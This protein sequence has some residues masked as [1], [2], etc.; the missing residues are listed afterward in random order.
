LAS[1][2]EKQLQGVKQQ[3]IHG[4]YQEA[5]DVIGNVLNKKEISKEDQLAFKVLKCDILNDLGNHN[6]ALELAKEVLK[7]SEKLDKII[8][9][10]DASYQKAFALL[11]L[12]GKKDEALISIDRGLELIEKTGFDISDKVHILGNGWLLFLKGLITIG[13]GD[14]EKGIEYLNKSLLLAEECGNKRLI[15]RCLMMLGFAYTEKYEFK[16]AEEYCDKAQTIALELDNKFLLALTYFVKAP[17]RN[18]KRQFNE[19]IEFGE[20]AK[21]MLNEIGSKF[22]LFAL[23]GNLA[24][25]YKAISDFDTALEYYQKA[26]DYSLLQQNVT[27]FNMANLFYLKYDLKQSQKY[28]QKALKMSEEI[29]DLRIVPGALYH[30]VVLSIELDEMQEAKQYLKQLKQL[31]KETGYETINLLYCIAEIHV[32]KASNEFSDWGKAV[33]KLNKLLADN[34]LDIDTRFQALNYLLEIRIKELQISKSKE[35]LTEVKKQAIRLEVE[36][37]DQQRQ[38]LLFSVYR[39]QSQIALIEYDAKNA[40]ALLDKAQIIADSKNFEIFHVKLREDREKIAKQMEMLQEL[41][42]QKAP[43]SETIKFVSLD[44]T[45][46]K[47]KEET[48]VEE[49]DQETGKIIEYRKLF[50]IKI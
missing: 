5:L 20:K 8:L 23:F 34:N 1:T 32:L 7:E 44:K 49:R 18:R 2:I 6:E 37:E 39:L 38:S 17:I 19:A 11:Y 28:Y 43:L 3:I 26:L 4:Q 27:I 35:A 9:Q 30:L 48:V 22:S 12:T 29:G 45:F 46:H 14:I 10:I 41:Q 24:N 16:R 31:H 40:I 50:T 33:V 47:I 15:T 36:A 42:E 21:N 25:Y 13:F